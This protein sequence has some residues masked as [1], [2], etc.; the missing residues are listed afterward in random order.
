MIYE[1]PE[2]IQDI[3]KDIMKLQTVK[4]IYDLLL[5]IYPDFIINILLNYSKDYPHFDIN[6]IGMCKTLKVSKAQI[7][8]VDEY[9]QDDNHI[10]LKLFSEL[11]T[12]A[13]FVIRKYTEFFPCPICNSGLP[14]NVIYNKLKENDIDIPEKWDKKCVKC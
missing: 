9:P 7:I 14:S 3:I 12:Q 11:L 6:W 5:T 2:N 8:L 4:E 13:G 1:D 10:L